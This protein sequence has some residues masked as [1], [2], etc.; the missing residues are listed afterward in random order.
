MESKRQFV[1]CHS[2][3]AVPQSWHICGPLGVGGE[4]DESWSW[5]APLLPLRLLPFR[6][7]LLGE[8]HLPDRDGVDPA[9]ASIKYDTAD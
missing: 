1:Q 6:R 9:W 5:F 4:S 3:G 8:F 7:C 2:A